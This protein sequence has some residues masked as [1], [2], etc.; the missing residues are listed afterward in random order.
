MYNG[1]YGGYGF[2]KEAIRL[3]NERKSAE[4]SPPYPYT[5]GGHSISRTDPVMVQ[6]VRELGDKA[7]SFYS[8]IVLEEIPA[9]Y[10][11]HYSITEYDGNETVQIEYDKY[12]VDRIREIM[13]NSDLLISDKTT[14]VHE[15]LREHQ[16]LRE[17]APTDEDHIEDS[18]TWVGQGIRLPSA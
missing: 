4:S 13:H 18:Q 9:R 6:I 16:A 17:S 12:A 11:N 7:N 15:I 2:S 1:S 10:A 3:Y 8:R 14:Q 5:Y